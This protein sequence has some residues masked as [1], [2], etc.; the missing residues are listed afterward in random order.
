MAEPKSGLSVKERF[1]LSIEQQILSGALKVGQRLPP[2]R[3]IAK[4]SGISRTVVHTGIA[5]L[6]AKN[7]LTVIPRKGTFV[8]DFKKEATL[9]LYNALLKHTGKL[10]ESI[11]DSLTEYRRIVETANARLAAFNRTEADIALLKE[12][13]QKE[14]DAVLPEERVELDFLFHLQIAQ[15][16]GNIVLPMAMRSAESMYKSLLGRFYINVEDAGPILTVHERAVSA[17][18]RRDAAEAVALMAHMLDY[19][20]KVL[21]EEIRAI[22]AYVPDER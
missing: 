9:E 8:K 7:V 3:E 16:T 14:R 2:E 17:I 18:E 6:A 12:T 5:E 1:T 20:E 11:V 19:G 21:K 22:P 13:L 15:A 10:D 4:R